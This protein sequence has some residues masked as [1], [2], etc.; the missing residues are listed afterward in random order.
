MLNEPEQAAAPLADKRQALM[1]LQ[2]RR[3]RAELV[4]GGVVAV[5][6][7]G[8][9]PLSWQ[10]LGLWFL[11]EWDPG[12]ATY[13]M[14]LVLRL[15]GELDRAGLAAA[16]RAVL[17]RHEG[18][19]TRFVVI[20]GQPWQVVDPAPAVVELPVVQL[21]GQGW[22][23]RVA[24]EVRR[25]FRLV[26]EPGFR[27]WLGRLAADDHV[28][29]LNFH[30]IV[31]DGWSVGILAADLSSAYRQATAA[32][33]AGPG[34]DG[35]LGLAPLPVQPADYAHW[36]HQHRDLLDAGLGYWVGQLA[37]LPSV[38]LPTDRPR[39]VLPTGAGAGL[40][41]DL[42]PALA[43]AV[44]RLATELAV[45]PLAV[46]LA[47]FSTVLHRY[48]GET[49][50]PIGSIFSGRTRSELEP[51]IGYLANTVVLRTRLDE[52][53]TVIAQIQ[54]CHDTIL[55]AM[56]YQ[57][58]PFSL[59]VD[60]LQPPRTP[61]QNP[62]FQIALSL[63]P[64][65]LS[66]GLRLG[67]LT[68]TEVPIPADTAR[69]DLSVQV[70]QQTDGSMSL[71]A[72]YS[73]E[74]FDEW[75]I[76]ALAEHLRAV[77]ASM[78]ADPRQR[79]AEVELVSEA[80]RD[81]VIHGFNQHPDQPPAPLPWA[82]SSVVAQAGTTARAVPGACAVWC[83]GGWL[84]Y[85][86]LDAQASRLAV[87]LAAAGVRRGQLVAVCG[88]RSLELVV[89]LLGVLKA[90]AAYLPVDPDQPVAR[91]E[92]QLADAGAVALLAQ[93]GAGPEPPAG[94]P[95]IALELSEPP[96]TGD[97][98][99]GGGTEE[100]VC[101]PGAD[102]LPVLGG[103]DPAYLIY[104]SGSTGTP[105]GV[106]NSHAGLINRL[107]WMQA[108]YPIDGRDRVLQKTPYTFDVSV[109]EFFWPLLTGARL[110]LA[111]PAGHR[112]P[113]YLAA[114]IAEQQISVSH[115]VPSVLSTFLDQPD[116]PELPALRHLFCSGE[117]L[118]AGT[119]DRALRQFPQLRLHN[120]YGPTEA[121]ID[122]TAWTCTA[123]DGPT[124]VIG[125]PITNMR[126]YVLD[127]AHRPVPIGVT[128][129]LH[130]AG[131]GL[132]TG[133]LNRPALTAE[134]FTPC[135]FDGPG[136]RMY[137]T[138]DLA[139][140]R[141]DGALEYHG[142]TDHQVKLNGQRIELGEIEHALSQHPDVTAAVVDLVD[143]GNGRPPFLAAYLTAGAPIPTDAAVRN[144]LASQLPLHM[145]PATVTVLDSLPLS[146]NGKLDRARLPAPGL[147]PA[148]GAARHRAVSGTEQSLIEIWTELLRPAGPP[149]PHHNFFTEGGSSLALARLTAAIQDRCGVRL[150]VRDLY[151]APT[152]E[153]MV[154]LVDERAA[155][156]PSAAAAQ[157]SLLPLRTGG[158][159]PPVFLVHAIG[160]SAVPY[161]PLVGLL[162]P[163]Q[164][165]YAFEAP[166]LHEQ[167][168][169]PGSTLANLASGYLEELR[170]VQPR[171]P[172]RLGG[173]SVGGL[174]AQQLAVDLRAAGEEVALLALLDAVP[175][176]PGSQ[177]PDHA[178]LL[179]W[180]AHDLVGIQGRELPDLDPE[181]LRGVPPN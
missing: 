96:H 109:W 33:A 1:Q 74:L 155:A 81:R 117:A 132:A 36:Q 139:R 65:A 7:D 136:E 5:G 102:A 158:S 43:G 108:Q 101:V 8:L 75:R 26:A 157:S 121:S 84:S 116:L 181:L 176:E 110:V 111:T 2:L 91:S 41:L 103:G 35:L 170:R 127:S 29:V 56:Q 24:A 115:F 17:V 120:L 124:V 54:H 171:G 71:W 19:R 28:L 37:D 165:V 10:Q 57:D 128:G 34:G 113:A 61:G 69:F 100:Y 3:R 67:G 151:L 162:D 159:R 123:V 163:A 27:W 68:V 59:L 114:V 15:R 130:L 126:A 143:P 73:T 45:S 4:G 107:G 83:D 177:V 55:R 148:P 175:S 118:P 14:P 6:R 23:Q 47:G 46:L 142:R 30:H 16:V 32:G 154:A 178:G 87:R 44:T 66:T 144:H 125:R 150:T 18:L 137:D 166:G 89:G 122:V 78:T 79:L 145:I 38:Q 80:E 161:L 49:D 31:T 104:T 12:S 106:L 179:S 99:E 20:D 85:A 94:I 135:P 174:I 180:F 21:P 119:R 112:D 76:R 58:I 105:K 88:H 147:E 95:R 13:H 50:L 63:L 25:P 82:G 140:W 22:Q 131:V 138:G 72:E 160:G 169:Q 98:D 168:A 93:P 60:T 11:Y 149:E 39:P 77:L 164:P 173:W 40:G 97:P 133:Y 90:G 53:S 64:G 134:R 172:Y 156:R 146:S 153:A 86:Q 141:P 52:H 48:T 70:T 51:L 42:D 92:F 167:P 152:L 9:L 129:R 62:L